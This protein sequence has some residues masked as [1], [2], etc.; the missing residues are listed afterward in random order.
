MTTPTIELRPGLDA[1]EAGFVGALLAT[2][3]D[4]T[5]RRVFADW[6]DE[7]ARPVEAKYLREIRRYKFVRLVRQR[8]WWAL[9]PEW[10]RVMPPHPMKHKPIKPG[11]FW[12]VYEP[13]KPVSSHPDLHE[14]MKAIER[15]TA[16]QHEPPAGHSRHVP[17]SDRCKAWIEKFK[18]GWCPPKHIRSY[19]WSMRVRYYG[20][21]DWELLHI[22]DRLV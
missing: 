16:L 5:A 19:G 12:D 1:E 11:G 10:A 13:G 20:V 7:H 2:P 8:G 18:R 21:H 14:A 4:D 17:L 9:Y 6:L 3:E 22:I 15:Q